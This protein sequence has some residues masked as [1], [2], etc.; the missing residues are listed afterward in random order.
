MIKVLELAFS[1]YAV[2]DVARARDFYE[3]VL[4]LKPTNITDTP[5][6]Q[7][8]EYSFGPH[9]LALGCAPGWKPSPDGA[10]VAFEVDDFDDT[11]DTLKQKGV[12]FRMEPFPTPVCR[13][14]MIYDPD[15]NTLC[16]HKRN[17][18]HD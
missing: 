4:G 17:A 8:V 13:M 16:I 9:A 12:R 15:G 2:T 11:I 7:W 10:V 3:N 14:A 5:G 18:G 1:S 6:G